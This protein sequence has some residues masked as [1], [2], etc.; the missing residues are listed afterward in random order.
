MKQEEVVVLLAIF[1]IGSFFSII[2]IIRRIRINNKARTLYKIEEARAS[3]AHSRDELMKLVINRN[4]DEKSTL[5]KHLYYIN[6]VYLRRPDEYGKLSEWLAYS[7]LNPKQNNIQ[8][9]KSETKNISPEIQNVFRL[10]S[11][12]IGRIVVDNSFVFNLLMKYIKMKEKDFSYEHF[13][14]LLH[15]I[16]LMNWEEKIKAEKAKKETQ[17]ILSSNFNRIPQ[18][19]LA[20]LYC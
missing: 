7:L 17:T 11:E 9:I 15:K 4:L 18:S 19:N 14:T 5:F 13:I 3:F 16:G 1:T 2:S 10:T 12:S 8:R 6:T 20:G